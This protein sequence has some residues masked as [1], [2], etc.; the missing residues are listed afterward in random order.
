[1]TFG[2]VLTFILFTSLSAAVYVV[3][4]GFDLGVGMLSLLAPRARDRSEMMASITTAWYGNAIWLLLALGVLLSA[5][6]ATLALLPALWLPLIG[7]TFGLALRGIG[8]ALRSRVG[9]LGQACDVAFGAGSVIVAGCQGLALGVFLAGLPQG[10]DAVGTFAWL[11]I[12]GLLCAAGLVGGYALLG[13]GWLVWRT[14]GAVRVF[15]REV[16]RSAL[17]LTAGAVLLAAGWAALTG[18]I[19]ALH[20]SAWPVALAL[21]VLVVTAAGVGT[22]IWRG[23][24]SGPN[25]N[26]FG[27]AVALLMAIFAGVLVSLWPDAAP[28]VAVA[29]RGAAD[30]LALE[31]TLFDLILVAPF[32]A[33]YLN[34]GRRMLSGGDIRHAAA[35]APE[36]RSHAG[37][38]TTG[39]ENSL[40]LS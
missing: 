38:R 29:R 8:F 11:S 3:T 36:V 9:R 22:L 6:P 7:M 25:H 2:L 35:D 24:W 18:A 5:F 27:L 28:G 16:A 37:R 10:K 32:V 1:M 33:A 17:I 39:L 4:A 21:T 23:L 26:V 13:A 20:W 12:L 30:P 31:Y 34:H 19:L 15:G 14:G 40:H